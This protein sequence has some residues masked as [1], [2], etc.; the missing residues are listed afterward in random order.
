[1]GPAVH[2]P[3]RSRC[4]AEEDVGA[5]LDDLAE[6]GWLSIHDVF[7]GRGNVDHVAVGPGGIFSIETKSHGGRIRLDEIDPR[8]LKQAYAEAKL[9]EEVSGLRVEPLL[10]FSRAYLIGR[11]PWRRR[12]VRILPARMLAGFLEGRGGD[13]PAERVEAVHR[14]LLAR[15][16]GLV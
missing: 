12:G 5:I 8:H 14:N 10:V 6:R 7:T 15:V 9:I 16:S 13:I 4:Q 3:L 2:R 1:L 11:G